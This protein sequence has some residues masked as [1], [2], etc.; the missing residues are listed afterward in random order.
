MQKRLHLLSIATHTERLMCHAMWL[1]AFCIIVLSCHAQSQVSDM[2]VLV[3]RKA[4]AQRSPFYQ[5]GTYVMLS[6]NYAGQ[7]VTI[8]AVK[9]SSM[10]AK[11]SDANLRNTAT[12]TVQFADGTKGHTG[13]MPVLPS[14]LSTYLEVIQDQQGPEA[15]QP[16]VASTS[17]ENTIGL[18]GRDQKRIE[19]LTQEE[20]DKAEQ[21]AGQHRWIFLGANPL[22]QRV[23]YVQLSMPDALLYERSQTAKKQYLKYEPLKE[24]REQALT[25]YAHGY[26]SESVAEGCESITR[27]II[28]SDEAG[29]VLKESYRSYPSTVQWGNA[30]GANNQCDDMIAKFSIDDIAAVKAAARNGEFIVKVF[31]NDR[32]AESYKIKRKHQEKLALP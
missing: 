15:I 30:Y 9:P 2:K 11:L 22:N 23:P 20:V 26:V 28:L 14:M 17:K 3:G 32:P 12:I 27:V 5:P 13:A 24:D 6:N 19:M 1:A 31:S 21:G 16:S 7:R 25:I 8:L 10:F 29:S 4:I 18:E